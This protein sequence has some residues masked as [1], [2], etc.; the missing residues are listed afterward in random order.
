MVTKVA[1]LPRS[2]ADADYQKAKIAE[3]VDACRALLIDLDRKVEIVLLGIG[4]RVTG[5]KVLPERGTP[6]ERKAQRKAR[7]IDAP[8]PGV[9]C[10]IAKC[11]SLTRNDGDPKLYRT[12]GDAATGGLAWH[13]AKMHPK[14]S[15][16]Q[17]HEIKSARGVLSAQCRVWDV[18]RK[19][20]EKKGKGK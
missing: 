17:K 9:A 15:P 10:P 6:A 2:A 18:A 1:T 4:K 16:A 12:V 13:V 20:A 8:R 19:A 14:P 11:E 7:K 5:A 3:R